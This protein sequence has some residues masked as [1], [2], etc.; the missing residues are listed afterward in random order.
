MPK[1][2]TFKIDGAT[3]RMMGPGRSGLPPTP[4]HGARWRGRRP[5]RDPR[6]RRPMGGV[7]RGVPMW[8]V[9]FAISSSL[10]KRCAHR[11]AFPIRSARSRRLGRGFT[12]IELLVVIAIIAVLIGLL[13]P[14]VQKVREAAA[15]RPVRQQPQAARPGHAQLP[16]R[17][18]SRS[19]R[20]YRGAA[21]RRPGTSTDSWGSLEP[22]V[23]AA[24]LHGAGRRS[25]TP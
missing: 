16:C 9:L 6:A 4:A 17:P 15:P 2:S 8:S 18:T 23:H 22:A 21:I 11:D 20:S 14:A 24:R 12:L 10:R 5:P 1:T 13:L 7:A 19:R 3:G 25:T